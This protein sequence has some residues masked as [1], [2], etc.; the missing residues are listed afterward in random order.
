M[1]ANTFL[2]YGE[3]TG[4]NTYAATVTEAQDDSILKDGASFLI[5]FT[6]ANTAADPTLNINGTGA[7]PIRYADAFGLKSGAIS[8]FQSVIMVTYN[9]TLASWMCQFSSLEV[10]E[11]WTDTVFAAG[12]YFA[13]GGTWTVASGDVTTNRYKIIGKTMYWMVEVDTTT[14]AGG[15]TQLAVKIP[16]T[17][18]AKKQARTVGVYSNAGTYDFGVLVTLNNGSNNLLINR[19]GGGAFA[20]GTNDQ[21]ISFIV[22]FEIE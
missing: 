18:N 20:N 15:P 2:G 4:T 9:T 19:W 12:D 17:K 6:N 5:K 8:G 7:K 11:Q 1:A 16:L 21:F 22:T 14:I 13:S 10:F 3:T